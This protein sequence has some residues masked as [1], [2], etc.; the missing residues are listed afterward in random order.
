MVENSSEPGGASQTLLPRPLPA[1]WVDAV[2]VNPVGRVARSFGF[3]GYEEFC[4][5]FSTIF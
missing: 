2:I 3:L 4:Q 5:K 1:T